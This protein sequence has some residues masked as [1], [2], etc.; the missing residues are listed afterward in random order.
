MESPRQRVVVEGI[1]LPEIVRFP[2]LL[3]SAT[4]AAQPPRLL[5]GLM[6]ILVLLSGGWLWDQFTPAGIAPGGLMGP[7]WSVARSQSA[8]QELAQI[9]TQYITQFGGDSVP[10]DFQLDSSGLMAALNQKRQR[11]LQDQGIEIGSVP[12]QELVELDAMIH[13]VGQLTPMGTF[14]ATATASRTAFRSMVIGV[15][16]LDPPLVVDNLA[17]LSM[18]IPV[19][20]WRLDPSFTIIFGFFFLATAGIAGGAISRM[21]ACDSAGARKLTTGEGFAF[22]WSRRER[23]TMSLVLP[24]LI[25]LVLAVLL[26][27]F[28]LLMAVPVLDI[29]AS[30]LF[31]LAMLVGF[32]AAF[33]LLGFLVGALMI[34]PAIA[35]E[36]CDAADALQRSW[37]YM[38]R[39]PAHY[40]G[41][42]LVSLVAL[43]FGT[44]VIDALLV[45]T[46]HISGGA[47][48]ALVDSPAS[49]LQPEFMA[50]KTPA[51]LTAE[52]TGTTQVAAGLIGLWYFLAFGLFL[53][54]LFSFFFTAST[55]TY[56]L[57]R[58][59][60]D[61][62]DTSEIMSDDAV[63]GT[64]M[65]TGHPHRTE[66][67]PPSG[68][69]TSELL[70][71]A[72]FSQVIPVDP[73]SASPQHQDAPAQD[74]PSEKGD[75]AH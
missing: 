52:F 3:G 65:R 37:A 75:Q 56:L 70:V 50:M 73:Q 58:R 8:T 63:P 7:D 54:Y 67:P 44:L 12:T 30:I 24:L 28:G 16:T 36:D 72:G 40:I 55:R 5:I 43:A 69:S 14:E 71:R 42:A 13:R 51:E 46:L 4:A 25:P 38:L 53:A 41:Y 32:L 18:R 34:V 68:S 47:F 60:A 39:K 59:A 35:V 11:L 31:G 26:S 15:L 74:P 22:A 61:G 62:Q 2:R 29:I 27:I 48:S 23:L 64:P 66:A 19:S 10:L 6:A 1:N 57:M 9:Q 49:L 20:L 45:V 21:S 33:S 17:T